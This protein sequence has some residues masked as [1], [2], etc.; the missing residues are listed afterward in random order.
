MRERERGE[1][2][3]WRQRAAKGG[4]KNKM[5]PL[6]VGCVPTYL[7]VRDEDCHCGEDLNNIIQVG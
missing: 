7:V 2:D 6:V 5:C 3:K 1:G 4:R